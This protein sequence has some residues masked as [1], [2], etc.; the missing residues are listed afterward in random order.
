MEK[1]R[2]YFPA[3]I[4]HFVTQ[5]CREGSDGEKT[6]TARKFYILGVE[7]VE[8]EFKQKIASIFLVFLGNF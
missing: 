8:M 5:Q 1:N 4:Y 3:Y 7:N 2:G 6:L